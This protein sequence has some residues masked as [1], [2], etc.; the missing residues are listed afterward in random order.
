[1]GFRRGKGRGG[2]ARFR[3]GLIIVHSISHICSVFPSRFP[4]K[5][6]NI[7]CDLKKQALFF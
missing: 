5:L 1:M 7:T 2:G 6:R 4:L 3:P